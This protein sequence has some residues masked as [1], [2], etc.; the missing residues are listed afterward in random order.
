[1]LEGYSASSYSLSDLVQLNTDSITL[2]GLSSGAYM[3]V[4]YSIAH[5]GSINGT[6]V[7]AGGPFYCAESTL[8]L[9]ESRCMSHFQ[10]DEV[11]EVLAKYT[12]DA[13]EVGT[14]DDVENLRNG[15]MR[16]YLYSGTDD[17][18]VD[19]SV[20][21]GLKS[22]LGLMG[23]SS[24]FIEGVFDVDSEHCLPTDASGPIFEPCATLSE[25]YIGECN[26]DGAGNALKAILGEEDLKPRVNMIEDNLIEY[27]QVE[28]N[29][30]GSL[31]SINDVGYIYIPTSCQGGNTSASNCRLHVSFHGC[32]QN[33]Q[34]IGDTYARYSGFN[35]WAEAN[36]IVVL[37]P[38]V[39]PSLDGL[40]LNP[41]GCW[42]WWGYTNDEY[43]LKSGWQIEFVHELINA[44]I[45]V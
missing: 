40:P 19:P 36:N 43:G 26:Y 33:V 16:F 29:V 37:Y 11:A 39:R 3:A 17:S 32:K 42:D 30:H 21:Q 5:S 2:S 35:E 24:S 31:S 8:L 7:F 44:I 18:V 12:F 25:P 45:V 34:I 10:G 38:Y 14:I 9:A 22:Y 20:M 4:Q 23:V 15:R 28:Y 6:A 41:K 13:S 27:S 1:M